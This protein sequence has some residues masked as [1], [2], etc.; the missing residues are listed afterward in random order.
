LGVYPATETVQ[1]MSLMLNDT[2]DASIIFE[3]LSDDNL[4]G[5]EL[6]EI[7][8]FTLGDVSDVIDISALLSTDATESKWSE[9]ITV[10]YNAENDRA[11]ISIDRDGSAEQYHSENLVV[12]LNQPNAFDLDD[13]VQNNQIIIG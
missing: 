7:D 11:V 4:G 10:D 1:P 12:L 13:L 9:F 3:L 6:Q 5:N 2:H 8:G